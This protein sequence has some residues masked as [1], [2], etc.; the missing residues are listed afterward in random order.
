ML[1]MSKREDCSSSP[2]YLPLSPSAAAHFETYVADVRSR[3]RGATG[4]LAGTL[5]KAP[6]HVLRLSLVLEYLVWSET[7]FRP[8]PAHVGESAM[9]AA[10][11]L[12]DRYFIPIA[13]RVFGEAAIPE[14]DRLGMELAR[15]IARTKPKR[16]NARETR[17]SIRG[18]LHD[19]KA[20]QQAC[21][22]LT[23]ACWIRPAGRSSGS[24]V[25][26]LPTNYEVNPALLTKEKP[27]E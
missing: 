11:G 4:Q 21:A 16:F 23:E 10:I 17:R 19:S 9:L 12:V 22:V 7:L 1:I 3:A 26:R 8:E 18:P 15:W 25:G 2:S 5:G 20:M 24:S 6:G 14:E 13:Q 27:R